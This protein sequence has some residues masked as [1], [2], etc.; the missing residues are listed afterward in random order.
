MKAKDF[1]IGDWFFDDLGNLVLMKEKKN[2]ICEYSTGFFLI[3]SSDE[4]N[5]YPLTLNNKMI[6]ESIQFYYKKLCDL[7]KITPFA[8]AKLSD[9]MHELMNLSVDNAPDEDFSKIYD[10]IGKWIKSI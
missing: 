9:Y 6:A 5:A 4:F 3:T 10:E 7:G 2:G 1:N 8:R